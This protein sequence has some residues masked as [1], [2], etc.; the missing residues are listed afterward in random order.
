M[1]NRSTLLSV[2][3]FIAGTLPLLSQPVIDLINPRHQFGEVQEASGILRHNFSFTNTGSDTLKILKL[4]VSH[5][6]VTA[7]YQPERVLPGQQGK[8]EVTL[9]PA[10][11][12]GKI[13][14]YISIR[15][16]DVAFPVRQMSLSAT[17]IPSVKT[18]EE[19]YLH[20]SGNLKFKSKHIAFDN[21]L[22]T[23]I[24]T[25]TFRIYNA[26]YKP[27]Q[28]SLATPPAYTRWQVIPPVLEAGKEGIIVLTY[29]AGKSE[30]WG[31][32]MNTFV[33][34]TNDSI[35][36]RKMITVGVNILEDFSYYKTTKGL[37][38]P[39]ISIPET[40]F[41]HG[42]ASPG[43]QLKHAFTV[44]NTGKGIL[45]IRKVKASCGCTIPQLEKEELKPG[46]STKLWV[47]FNTFGYSGK[48]IKTVTVISNDPDTPNLMLSVGVD[49][50]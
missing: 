11:L 21:F 27:M 5:P 47:E 18:T 1:L 23:E 37:E 13:E 45:K 42:N 4:K 20:R 22:N 31:L 8:V 36:S 17:I 49:L 44:Q 35:E 40:T 38:K 43:V 10:N 34:E 24:R 32:S 9:D 25:D 26:W 33:L 28:I 15:T 48:Q 19:T 50:P 14:R 12:S 30:N 41:H 7:T 39:V 6:D 3:L 46:E 2:F 16:N 29:D